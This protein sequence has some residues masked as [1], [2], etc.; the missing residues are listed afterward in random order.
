MSRSIVAVVALA[1]LMLFVD[2]AKAGEYTYLQYARG[3]MKNAC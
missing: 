3:E 2:S 1:S